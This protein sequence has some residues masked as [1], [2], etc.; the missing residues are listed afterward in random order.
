MGNKV[1][2]MFRFPKHK[3]S[4]RLL[5]IHKDDDDVFCTPDS[6]VS[7]DQ[8]NLVMLQ[9]DDSPSFVCEIC[10]EP[11][12][13]IESF[14]LKGCSHF[15]CTQCVVSYVASKLDDSITRIS[16]PVTK[17]E[18]VLEPEYCKDILPKKLFD[19][20]G[21][22]LCESVI[23]TSQ[24]IYCPFK[25]CSALLIHDTGMEIQSSYCPSCKRAFCVSCKVPWH[26][27]VNCKKFQKLKK[28]GDDVMMID[29]AKRKNWRRCP[30]CNFYVEKSTGCFYI[31][32]R[33]GYAFCYR[34]GTCS[35]TTSHVC[36]NPKCGA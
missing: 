18:G 14:S 3:K 34:C 7:D 30:K 28:K 20:W 17:C 36:P 6:S 19:R 16:C 13:L 29:L 33:C 25:D 15:Y 31:K 12:A 9:S 11:K 22:A 26:S 4:K 10:V 21:I 2:T 8:E 35:S 1:A 23:Q 5:L 24:K 32:C 27:E